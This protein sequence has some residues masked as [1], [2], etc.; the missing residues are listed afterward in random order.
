MK[1]IARWRASWFARIK[2]G[3]ARIPGFSGDGTQYRIEQIWLYIL[4]KN[5]SFNILFIQVN[6]EVIRGL[7]KLLS[8]VLAGTRF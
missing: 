6:G 7:R 2:A 4:D 1:Y 8:M 5:L 3:V